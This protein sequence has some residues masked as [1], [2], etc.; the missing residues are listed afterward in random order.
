[1]RGGRRACDFAKEQMVLLGREWY[2]HPNGQTPA[3]EWAFG[4][5]GTGTACTKL[6]SLV[7]LP[8]HSC[9]RFL[10]SWVLTI[11]IYPPRPQN[12]SYEPAG[13]PY[14]NYQLPITNL[15]L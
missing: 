11:R 3:Y 6:V 5:G 13:L 15:A 12:C 9:N 4:A 10:L 8:Q 14:T 1:M 7:I 2:Q